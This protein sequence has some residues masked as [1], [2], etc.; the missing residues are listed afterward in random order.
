[1]SEDDFHLINN[2]DVWPNGCL[3]APYYGWLNPDQIYTVPMSAVS[4]PPTPG[5]G[6][7]LPSTLP[8]QYPA[9]VVSLGVTDV[10]LGAG[11]P[12]PS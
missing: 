7:N 9:E 2:T 12:A 1:V 10:A 11:A 4:R 6:D 3:I 5:T 8:P